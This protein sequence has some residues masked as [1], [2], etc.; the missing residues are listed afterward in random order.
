VW[1]VHRTPLNLWKPYIKG[2]PM[3]PGKVNTNPGMSW[4]GFAMIS[5]HPT[6]IYI[7]AEGAEFRKSIP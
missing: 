3:Q 1:I 6:E 2:V 4:P 7:G 5:T